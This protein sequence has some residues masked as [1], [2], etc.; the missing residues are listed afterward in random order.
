MVYQD[1][2][3]G[4]F[5]TLQRQHGKLNAAQMI[6]LANQIPIWG[7]NVLN[8]VFDGTALRLWASYAGGDQEAYQRPYV[9]LDLAKLDGDGDGKGDLAEGAQDRDGN[10]RPDFLDAVSKPK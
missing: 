2:G 6:A 5:P 8:A 7:G 9:F 1:E 10:G 3:C 4:A